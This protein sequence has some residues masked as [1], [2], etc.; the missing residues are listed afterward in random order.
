MYFDFSSSSAALRGKLLHSAVVPRPIAWVSTQDA[1]GRCNLAPFSFFNVFSTDPPI[2]GL[3]IGKRRPGEP[4][5]T[6]RNILQTGE[7][8]VNLVRFDSC[9]AMNVSGTDVDDGVSEAALAGL[10]MRES[11]Q[12]TPRRIAE[13]PV[14]M[15]C[16]LH[17]AIALSPDQH[18]ILGRIVAM[19][20]DE[21]FLT[22]APSGDPH[23]LTPEL[24]L[25]GRMHG[26]GWY[27][28]TDR[29]F[30][31]PRLEPDAL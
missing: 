29:L 11:R 22:P 30:Q 14:A 19:H 21:A 2:L 16:L 5:H 28:R 27:L 12:V 8:V 15:E 24:D 23:V 18:L 31:M 7:F 13:S 20:I 6:G 1:A 25:I 26:N 9:H 10:D 3:G 17:E 4:K